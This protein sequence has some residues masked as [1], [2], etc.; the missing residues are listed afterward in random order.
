MNMLDLM[1]EPTGSV[2]QIDISLEVEPELRRGAKQFA[3]AQRHL[4]AHG[5]PLA[6]ELVDGLPRD[7]QCF[8]QR[9]DRELIL[10]NEILTQDLTRMNRAPLERLS[11]GDG[12][13]QFLL[14]VITDLDIIGV[15]VGKPKTDAPL[16]VDRDGVLASAIAFE[17]VQAVAGRDFE[18]RN[19]VRRMDGFEFP[20]SAAGDGGGQLL[21]LAGAK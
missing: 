6:Q 4:G 7:A 13:A 15:S 1:L 12:H 20:Q 14:M 2:P 17:C 8:G 11:I 9:R 18:I 3:K 19:L 5:A 21:G 16:V 10:R